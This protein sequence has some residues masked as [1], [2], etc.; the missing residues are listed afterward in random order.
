MTTATLAAR[1]VAAAAS[2]FSLGPSS[3]AAALQP[4]FSPEFLTACAPSGPAGLL[5]GAT[6]LVLTA[7]PPLAPSGRSG[8]HLRV[9]GSEPALPFRPAP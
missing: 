6:Q 5:P 1:L 9:N 2:C 4:C 7:T 8:F 3:P